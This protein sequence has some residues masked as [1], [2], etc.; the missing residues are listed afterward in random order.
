MIALWAIL[1]AA[2]VSVDGNV[3]TWAEVDTNARRA[4]T[5]RIDDDP[6]KPTPTVELPI[7]DGLMR[8]EGALSLGYHESGL[9]LRSDNLLGLRLLATQASE[10]MLVAQSRTSVT[11]A[12]L[13]GDFVLFLQALGKLRAQRFGDRTYGFGRAD[14][15]VE[16]AVIGELSLRGGVY[17]TGFHAFDNL[18]FS[19]GGG[20]ALVGARYGAGRERVDLLVAA[21]GRLYPWR[22]LSLADD[23]RRDFNPAVVLQFTSARRL[24]LSASY[25][26]SRNASNARGES[27]TRHRVGG[28]VGFRLPGQITCTA[29]ANVQLTQYDDGVSVGQRYFLGDDEESLNVFDVTLS[30]PL[31]GGLHAMARAAFYGNEL[32]AEGNRFSRQIAA[33]GI[34]AD[35]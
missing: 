2:Q 35:L 29:L 19:S 24:Y 5:G 32:A 31:L 18:L 8:A 30:R 17:G 28:V 16:R 12:E 3:I 9:L 7:A 1:I 11:K 23:D 14:A 13:P 26:L 20:G 27:F 34:R 22:A 4:S 21:A 6:L 33:V 15:I 25:L 10:R